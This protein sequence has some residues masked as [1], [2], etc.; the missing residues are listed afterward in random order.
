MSRRGDNIHKRKD[1]RWEG[2]YIKYRN[3]NNKAV[4]ASVYGKTYTE[5]KNKLDEAKTN[6][7]LNDDYEKIKF[8]YITDLW[9]STNRIHIKAATYNKYYNVIETHIKPVLGNLDINEISATIINQFLE[10]KMLSG[11]LDGSGGLSPTYVN[12][13]AIVVNS[14]VNFAVKEGYCSPLATPILKPTPNSNSPNALSNK[15]YTILTEFIKKNT[16]N[17]KL[18]IMLSLYAGLRIG[19]VC[20]LKWSDVDFE[21]SIIHISSTVSRIKDSNEKS[22]LII[23]TPKTKSS[24]RFIPIPQFLMGYLETFYDKRKSEFV[25]SNDDKFVNPRMLEYHFH[26]VLK[27]ANINQTNFHALRHTFATKCIEVGMDVKSLSEILGHAN[28]AITLK[29]YVHSSMEQKRLQMEKLIA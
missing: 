5:V 19:E 14:I 18:G 1:G 27:E 22:K 24:D 4:Y 13:I 8:S 15:E 21:K 28:S 16:D 2:R 29:I 17:T 23:D 10:E 6:L 12:T 7:Q 11:K 26:K 25:I 9:L 3:E 20:A